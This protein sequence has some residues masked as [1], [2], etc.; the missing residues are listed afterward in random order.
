M[1]KKDAP[2]ASAP[3]ETTPTSK[4]DPSVRY[5]GD[6]DCCGMLFP[7]RGPQVRKFPAQDNYPFFHN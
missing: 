2:Q 5:V 1:E 6:E 7:A 3:V 4:E